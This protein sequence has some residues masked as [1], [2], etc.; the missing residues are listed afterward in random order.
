MAMSDLRI[1]SKLLESMHLTVPE[2]CA[3][4]AQ[5]LSFA[6]LVR[7]ADQLLARDPWLPR[8]GRD[9]EGFDGVVIER[10]A[11]EIWVHECHEAGVARFGPVVSRRAADLAAAVRELLQAN[12]GASIDGI[13]VEYEA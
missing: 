5:C 8:W 9:R 13:P 12:G 2:R 1:H 11:E 6:A 4:P 10:R 7:A 3:L